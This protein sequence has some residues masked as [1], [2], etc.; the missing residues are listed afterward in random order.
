MRGCIFCVFRL[1][2]ILQRTL[3]CFPFMIYLLC[4]MS[5]ILVHFLLIISLP[6]YIFGVPCFRVCFFGI[7]SFPSCIL[8]NLHVVWCC[9]VVILL[10]CFATVLDV[11]ILVSFK[12]LLNG[13]VENFIL[14]IFEAEAIEFPIIRNQIWKHK[15]K[16]SLTYNTFFNFF[17]TGITCSCRLFFVEAFRNFTYFYILM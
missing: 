11:V 14:V 3:G 2:L 10:C 9:G 13:C 15:N 4:E 5:C 12:E 6:K 7:Y 1:W 8:L 16:L 17:V